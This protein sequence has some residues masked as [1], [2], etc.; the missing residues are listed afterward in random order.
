MSAFG[1]YC[2]WDG[3]TVAHDRLNALA[4][5]L[6]VAGPDRQ[7][8][9]QPH[10][11]LA[12]QAHLLHFDHFAVSER[13]PHPFGRGAVLT[14][15]GRLDNREDLLLVLHR[16]LRDDRSD[17]A[18]VAAAYERWGI[19]A[20]PHLVGDWCLAIW[21]AERR[22]IVLA[23]D[24]MGNRPLYYDATPTR[25]VWATRLEALAACEER[26]CD[27]D[28]AFIASFLQQEEPVD[29]T[30]F[31]GITALVP[32]HALV[33][34]R[35]GIATRRFW[36]YSPGLL[37]YRRVEEYGQHLRSLLTEAVRVR[38]RATRTVW[39]HLSGGWDSSSV[40]CLADRLIKQRLVEATALQP[41][42]LV[43]QER[44]A[45][46]ERRFMSE[47][48]AWC[49]LQTVTV[50]F[51][52]RP[53]F[54]ELLGHRVLVP[55]YEGL[56]ASYP[57][58]RAGDHLIL[59]GVMGDLYGPGTAPLLALWEPFQEGHPIQALRG[60]VA[61][62][63][64]SMRPLSRVMVRALRARFAPNPQT[65][66]RQELGISRELLEKVRGRVHVPQPS[67][68]EF[69]PTHQPLVELL[70]RTG[71]RGLVGANELFAP[72]WATHPFVHRPLVEFLLAVPRLALFSATHMRAG[73]QRAL[74]D[75]LPIAL[76]ARTKKVGL[77]PTSIHRARHWHADT[78]KNAPPVTEVVSSWQLTRRGIIAPESLAA[79]IADVRAGKQPSELFDRC[80]RIEAWLRSL[81]AIARRESEHPV[82][83]TCEPA[84]DFRTSS[85]PGQLLARLAL[86]SDVA[87]RVLLAEPSK[88]GG[89][90]DVQHA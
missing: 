54:A 23:R 44:E 34:T 61:Y 36:T 80:I 42:S 32:G 85:T 41:V 53:T 87:E 21:D 55:G 38:L 45:A 50:P 72:L 20:L 24:Y 67:C 3:R 29:M 48:E 75:I 70:Y 16:L 57:P 65:A 9:V 31:A 60:Y 18:L 28:D 47:V 63:K 84:D 14:W 76:L 49:E 68:D 33:A 81:P 86:S 79:Q 5:Q 7:A 56:G 4:T 26:F 83:V 6:Q 52:A 27:P 74:A 2:F 37:R 15:D 8:T 35:E 30:P 11:W 39:A 13:Q 46:G 66:I 90:N 89:D 59:T 43:Y 12:L 82:A 73:M 25:L 40:V 64:T 51:R 58:Y 78:T 88:K 71:D 22:Q 62:A 10:P 19:E 69:P 77:P 1:G 17:A